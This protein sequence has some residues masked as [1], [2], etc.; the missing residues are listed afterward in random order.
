MD[1]FARH[2]EGRRCVEE[3]PAFAKPVGNSVAGSAFIEAG[4]A[5][6]PRRLCPE[7]ALDEAGRESRI[8]LKR[9]SLSLKRKLTR[10][11]LPSQGDAI[12]PTEISRTASLVSI[13][14]QSLE[15]SLVAAG[16]TRL[17]R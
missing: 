1:E 17:L 14:V 15:L 16:K 4:R 7:A 11:F 6:P 12:L 5:R 10:Y 8:S 2:P 3:L 9:R 13:N